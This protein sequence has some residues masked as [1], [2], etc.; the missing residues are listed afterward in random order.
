MPIV[1]RI[2]LIIFALVSMIFIF[3]AVKKDKLLLK[4][5]LVWLICGFLM[6]LAI[7]IPNLI[8]N[9]SKMMGFEAS[10][11]MIFLGGFAILFCITFSLTII[12]SRQSSKIR[13]LIQE[14]SLL[15]GKVVNKE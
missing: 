1:L 15:K 11:N 13:L 14:V 7:I 3:W 8:E 9:L 4:Y 6:I 10:S 12:I 2:E 5:A